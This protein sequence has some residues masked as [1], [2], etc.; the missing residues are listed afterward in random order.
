MEDKRKY[1]YGKKKVSLILI[2]IIMLLTSINKVDAVAMYM[3]CTYDQTCNNIEVGKCSNEMWSDFCVPD[4]NTYI[5]FT[6]NKGNIE[7][8]VVRIKK[9]EAWTVL[10][11]VEEFPLE[12][13]KIP[14]GCWLKQYTEDYDCEEPSQVYDSG[15]IGIFENGTCPSGIV[16]QRG[17][18]WTR[19][20]HLADC[21]GKSG[22]IP[23]GGLLSGLVGLPFVGE[24]LVGASTYE[25]CYDA[26]CDFEQ[27]AMD[28]EFI[29]FGSSGTK[30]EFSSID[31]TEYV[32][33]KI[34]GKIVAEGYNVDGRYCYIGPNFVNWWKDEITEYQKNKI[35]ELGKDYWRVHDN[36]NSRLIAYKG[37]SLDVGGTNVCKNKKEKDCTE[38][39]VLLTSSDTS[40]LVG[41]IN[42]WYEDNKERLEQYHELV[43]LANKEVFITTSEELNNAII[44]GKTFKFNKIDSNGKKY[45][46]ESLITDLESAYSA[47]E[48][49]YSKETA[50]IDYGYYAMGRE[51]TTS[52]GSSATSWVY[53]NVLG[54]K[55]SIEIALKEDQEYYLNGGY[56]VQALKR[57]VEKELKKYIQN[58]GSGELNVLDVTEKLNE[59]VEL[60]YTT[61]M[62]LEA[63]SLILNLTAEQIAR[64]ETL[65]GNFESLVKN[66][67]LDIYP[68]VDCESLLGSE[69][70][71]K[72]K[73]YTNII[74]IA[75]PI[76]LITFGIIDFT[77]AIFSC[78]EDSMKKMQKNAS[79]M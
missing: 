13:D 22:L 6:N 66:K 1:L 29:P 18:Q 58:I 11:K 39:D 63:N 3:E 24:A 76:I 36:F 54:I 52:P 51:V 28:W 64:L 78:D 9:N 27:D 14:G 71:D 72:I 2:T 50:T 7:Y 10:N 12:D 31:K 45:D 46:Q 61:S 26:I 75:V 73:S 60:F 48:K 56:L 21:G 38:Q 41:P 44:E 79:W 15:P 19:I 47:L 43:E 4:V 70:I 5:P 37:D 32:F 42:D 30:N 34:N 16:F 25:S 20:G 40:K 74:K 59:Y 77:K 49:A 68:I 23:L 65:N 53:T 33:Y 57:D 67:K 69:L 55:E 62:Y 35:L 8:R 17:F